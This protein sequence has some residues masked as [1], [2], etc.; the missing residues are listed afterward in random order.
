MKWTNNYGPID[1]RVT[2]ISV[3]IYIDPL[4]QLNFFMVS[5]TLTSIKRERTRSL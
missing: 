1:T 3:I 5:E 4:L 2:E